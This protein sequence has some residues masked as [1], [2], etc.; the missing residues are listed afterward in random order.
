MAPMFPI[1]TNRIVCWTLGGIFL[2]SA[3]QCRAQVLEPGT[4][5]DTTQPGEKQV[6]RWKIGMVVHAVG[7]PCKGLFGTVPLP[8]EWPEQKVTVV[9]EE[10][11]PTVR[12][13]D[14]R[15]E[16]VKQMLVRIPML[17]AGATA[18]ALLT[19]EIR[20]QPISAPQDPSLFRIPEN[21]SRETRRYL[22][23]SPYIEVRSPQIR[24]LA[25]E[26]ARDKESAWEL[27]EGI[28]DHVRD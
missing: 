10:I 20:R 9:E 24:S 1:L 26:L 15:L 21:P 4:A 22:A 3:Q 27:V 12:V 16:G 23:A 17:P 18:K 25:R 19:V 5:Q 8:D 11:S 13:S 6:T 2:V 28:F 7:G 14:R